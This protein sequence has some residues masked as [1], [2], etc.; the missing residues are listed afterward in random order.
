VGFAGLH[1]EQVPKR[2]SD[3]CKICTI[4]PAPLNEY[5]LIMLI[6]GART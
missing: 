3:Y 5:F 6:C 1:L 4:L 2:I